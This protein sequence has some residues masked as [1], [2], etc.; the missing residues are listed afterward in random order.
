MKVCHVTSAHPNRDIRIFYKECASLAG[1]GYDV[2]LVAQGESFTENGVTVTGITP[3]RSRLQ[4][5]LRT[6]RAAYKTALAIDAEIYHLHDP[7]LLPYGKKLKKKGKTVIFD[8]HE[9]ILGQVAN[10]RWI[11]RSLRRPV[12][13]F[14]GRYFKRVCRRMD[15]VI[16]VTPHLQ[17]K[18]EEIAKRTVMI[19]NYPI[20]SDRPETEKFPQLTLGFAGGVTEQW[21]H[22]AVLE[23]LKQL[24]EARYLLM[25]RPDAQYLERLK[26]HPSWEQADYRGIVSH[27]EALTALARSHIGVALC[28]YS[29]NTDGKNGSVGNTKLFEIMMLGLPAIATGYVLWREII[30][31]YRCGICVEPDDSA[32]IVQAITYISAHPEQAAEMGRNGQKA[33]REIY[34][35]STQEK[36]LL[37]LYQTLK[38]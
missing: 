13:F 15:A 25:G 22:L 5:F 33:V 7:E 16:T 17:R 24:P 35:W 38:V 27:E 23:A 12:E 1:N 28:A 6:S 4:R 29:G 20:L 2:Y 11:P 32:Q 8:S 19:T 10:K 18:F 3:P 30:E 9:D 37:E 14:A 34:N 31:K 21:N 36:V 26:A